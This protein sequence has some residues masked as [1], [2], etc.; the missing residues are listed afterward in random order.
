MYFSLGIK[1]NGATWAWGSNDSGELG[2]NN[3]TSYS[4]PVL[5]VG[6]HSFASVAAAHY[7]N[8]VIGSTLALKRNG[9]VWAWGNN[10]F[11]QA[12]TNN[13]TS[14]SSP[15]LVVGNHSFMHIR[16]SGAHS[17]ALKA[18]G[19]AWA[20]GRNASG[21]LGDNTTTNKS[22]PVLVVGSHV[23]STVATGIVSRHSAALK[24]NG[25]AWTW[26]YNGGGELGDNTTASKS[27]PVLVV[28]SH[29]FIKIATGYETTYGLKANGEVWAWGRNADGQLGD[30]TITNKSSPVL[31][32]GNH[33]FID[34]RGTNSWTVALKAN[35]QVWTWGSNLTGNLG[36]GTE[37]GRSSPVLVVGSHSF[38][39][40]GIGRWHCT[41]I[42]DTGEMWAWGYN[43]RGQL[44]D[45]TV[46]SY[47]SP[48]LV[49]GSH[50]FRTA[51]NQAAD[52]KWGIPLVGDLQ[53]DVN[54]CRAMG[55]TSP[56][57]DGLLL[58]SVYVYCDTNHSSQVRLAVYEGGDLDDPSGAT[59]L[60]DFGQTTGS[61]TGEWLKLD[62]TGE[63][64][65]TKNTPLWIAVKGNDTGFGVAYYSATG[66]EGDFQA[67]RGRFVSDGSVSSDESVAYPSTWPSDA[68]TFADFWYS[69]YLE[70]D[71]ETEGVSGSLGKTVDGWSGAIPVYGTLT[72]IT[73]VDYPYCRAKIDTPAAE[74]YY[75]DMTWSAGN[76]RFE[77]VIYPGSW[78]ANGCADPNNGEFDV[79]VQLSDQEDFSVIDY[80]SGG[81]NFTTY[82][83][84]RKS[85]KGTG[86]DYMDPNPVWNEGEGVWDYTVSDFVI[87]ADAAR[88][89]IAVAIPFHPV[90]ADISITSVSFDGGA[91]SEGSAAST[92]NA[93][94]WDE[95][96]HTLYVQK[97]SISTTEV[98]VDI[99][100]T[101]DTDL[102]V[103]RFDRI[104]T[105]DMGNRLFYNGLIIST[106]YLTTSVIGGGHPNSGMQVE[107]HAKEPGES[108]VSTDCFERAC[109]HVD[110]TIR[111]DNTGSYAANIKW[112]R[113][114]WQD[115][116]VL[117]NNDE[118]RIVNDSDDTA[119][120][121]WRQQQD[122][123]IVC[124]RTQI[125]RAGCRFIKN[126][127]E[128]TNGDSSSHKYPFVWQREQWIG[129]DRA[130]NDRGR[131]YG[132]TTDVAIDARNPL[133]IYDKEWFM[134]YDTTALAATAVVFY[135][136]EATTSTYGVFTEDAF[137]LGGSPYAVWPIPIADRTT[138]VAENFG[139]E[140]TW[141]SV[142]AGEKVVLS[143]YHFHYDSTSLSSIIDAIDED[144]DEINTVDDPYGLRFVTEDAQSAASISNFTPP[145][146]CSVSFWT[147]PLVNHVG[148][149]LGHSDNW[150]VGL[151]TSVGCCVAVN[152]MNSS[153]SLV[154]ST[155]MCEGALSHVVMTCSSDNT[156]QIFVNGTLDSS[157]S[158]GTESPGANTLILGSDSS[159][160][161]Y[162]EAHTE[163][164]RIYNRVLSQAEAQTIYGCK[165]NDNIRDGLLHRY[166]L[167]EGYEDSTASGSGVIK[168]TGPSANNMTPTN[169]PVYYG[170][171]LKINRLT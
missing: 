53:T 113:E 33:S 125:Y 166:L 155:G 139:F 142:P 49:V 7:T 141:S 16:S 38:I 78:Y 65:I 104:Q 73:Q 123:D 160:F 32:V 60:Y 99:E 80:S 87:Q 122:T 145:E 19:E 15:V 20:W 3:A 52:S 21:E 47:S 72:D 83:T 34:I 64:S 58:K 1:S 40:V 68:G 108:E 106:A 132:D 69:F 26:G 45:N 147:T 105:A 97:A 129:T 48:V 85:S 2:T 165:G 119:D 91:V 116:I 5:V 82:I 4:S 88:S 86:Y 89:N 124:R 51:M 143:F 46:T 170:T 27:S 36:D 152:G 153:T 84:R 22:S 41:A 137:I 150:E 23:F 56:D 115:Y 144:Y 130:T 167:N 138:T 6:S 109:V 157:D 79:T 102:W 70:Y 164:V 154:G 111:T 134:A 37:T 59:L 10:D 112:D 50:L 168:D 120:S 63:V 25:E 13:T 140:H 92:N 98:D 24:A 42:K 77:G 62:V 95:D 114:Q 30:N 75:V 39:E 57:K 74:T 118:I 136:V 163:D 100:F 28:G 54:W 96:T 90:T 159:S 158:L 127:Y 76:S 61:A 117:E 101:S 149:V 161:N 148:K 17:I 18:N 131:F 169:S 31:V 103:T 133:S 107:G 8:T 128:F 135:N 12:G 93:W 121:G 67:G 146:N 162:L 11:G 171:Q 94:W 71:I 110:D 55:G 43:V 35:G 126:I 156:R 151:D 66:N 9:E 81:L 14:Y 44:G 29:S